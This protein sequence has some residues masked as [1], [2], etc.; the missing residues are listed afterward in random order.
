MIVFILFSSSLAELEIL[1]ISGRVCVFHFGFDDLA[2]QADGGDA[3]PQL[4]MHVD[5]NPVAFV[6]FGG[7]YRYLLF[8]FLPFG[9]QLQLFFFLRADDNLHL[10]LISKGEEEEEQFDGN[11]EPRNRTGPE[12]RTE[13]SFSSFEIGGIMTW[14]TI[15]S[16]QREIFPRRYSSSAGHDR[17]RPF[18]YETDRDQ[19]EH[20]LGA[21]LDGIGDAEIIGER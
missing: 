8:H 2:H 5:R 3:R 7:Q 13:M 11:T 9:L 21:I 19:K 6:L 12:L 1:S 10:V 20:D 15:D 18:A 16:R 4:V 17:S 14:E